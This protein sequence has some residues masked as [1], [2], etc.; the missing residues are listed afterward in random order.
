MATHLHRPLTPREEADARRT[1]RALLAAEA[2]AWVLWQERQIGILEMARWASI[3]IVAQKLHEGLLTQIA[4]TRQ[5]G[6]SAGVGALKHELPSL[7]VTERD[8]LI[9]VQFWSSIQ[10]ARRYVQRWVAQAN[11]AEGIPRIEAAQQATIALQGRAKGIVVTENSTAFS[12]ARRQAA[13]R[14]KAEARSRLVILERWDAVLDHV[15]CPLCEKADGETIRLGDS[16]TEGIP[17]AVHSRCRCTSHYLYETPEA[18]WL[19]TA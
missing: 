15:V 14:A 18:A 11:A 4:E 12:G 7:P 19:L 3:G 2:A 16:F 10:T 5:L 6:A 9:G 13:K 8:A 17:G 1:S